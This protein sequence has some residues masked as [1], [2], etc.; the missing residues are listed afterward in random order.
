MPLNT[1]LDE[2]K[3]APKHPPTQGRGRGG[4][5]RAR[6]PPLLLLL[7][8][9]CGYE[10]LRRQGEGVN[11]VDEFYGEDGVGLVGAEGDVDPAKDGFDEVDPGV[12][13]LDVGNLG[14]TSDRETRQPGSGTRAVVAPGGVRP[15][16][17]F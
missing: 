12:D 10:L 7:L 15:I 6:A 11:D 3:R 4:N 16:K 9:A 14:E 5:P 2:E 17:V 8:L 1:S 13:P